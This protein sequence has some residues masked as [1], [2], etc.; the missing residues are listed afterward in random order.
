VVSGFSRTT[1][2]D[3]KHGLIALACI[4]SFVA[5]IVAADQQNGPA[6]P[7]FEVASVKKSPPPATGTPTIVVFGARKGDN[8][9]TQNATLRRI[10]RSA[11]GTRYQMEGQI[12]GGPGWVDTDRFDIAAKML[13]MTDVE[14]MLAMVRALLAD[15]F[16]LQTHVE[17]RELSVYALVAAR[18]D[19]RLGSEMR[20]AGVD[21]DGL[22]EAQRQGTA[23]R[24]VPR[25]PGKPLPLCTTGIMFGP[26]VRIESG[27]MSIAQLVSALSQSIGRPVVDRTGLSGHFVVK[28]EFAAD[29]GAGSPL[30]PPLPG[31]A[32]AAPV[33]TPSLF[34]AIQEQLGLKLDARR[35]PT[36]VL[37]IDRAEQPSPD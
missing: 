28:L 4:A 5:S 6:G 33:D 37:V 36:E 32:A 14:D 12:V 11:Y 7:A 8:W 3:V 29:A 25:E 9:N 10:I 31:P 30:G 26:V 24:P 23:P 16:Q 20:P 19:G 18:S 17:T 27:G 21:C 35:E 13:P 15:R 34:A 22:R 1:E 2:I